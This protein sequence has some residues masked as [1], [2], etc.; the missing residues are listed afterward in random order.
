MMNAKNAAKR[1]IGFLF[2]LSTLAA[3]SGSEGAAGAGPDELGSAARRIEE[4]NAAI[5]ELMAR[6]ELDVVRMDVQHCLVGVGA[7]PL[8]VSAGA[9]PG[10]RPICQS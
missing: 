9:H 3:C 8:L 10:P 1:A 7:N 5:A 6:D 4:M 2:L